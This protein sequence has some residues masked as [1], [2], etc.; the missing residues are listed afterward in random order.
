MSIKAK[1]ALDTSIVDQIYN[2]NVRYITGDI[3]QALLLDMSDSL[4]NKITDKNVVGGFMSP[5][6]TIDENRLVVKGVSGYKNSYLRQYGN[7]LAI[8]SGKFISSSTGVAKINLEDTYLDINLASDYSKSWIYADSAAK[9]TQF[10][11]DVY[12][13]SVMGEFDDAFTTNSNVI[14]MA[15]V[16]SDRLNSAGVFTAGVWINNLGG[17]VKQGVKAS[18]IIAGG[19]GELGIVAKTDNVLYTWTLGF[20]TDGVNETL[21]R[22]SIPTANNL[23]YIPDNSGTLALVT[24]ISDAL[25]DYLPKAGGVMTGSIN[26]ANYGLNVSGTGSSYIQY[27]TGSSSMLIHNMT[28]GSYLQLY[29]S[30]LMSLQSGDGEGLKYTADYTASF[31]TRSLVDKGYV[32]NV[33]VAKAGGTMSGALLADGGIDITGTGGSDVMN[34]GTTNADVI[35]IGRVGATVNI[36]GAVVNEYATNAYVTDKL[37]TLNSGGGAATAIGVGFEIEEAASIVGYIKSNG[38]RDGYLFLSPDIAYYLNL[39]L[40]NLNSNRTLTV[41]DINGIIATLNGGQTFTSAVWNGTAI[42]DAYISS[43]VTWNAKQNALVSGTNIKS[44]NGSSLLGAGNLAVGDALV[45]NSLAQFAPTTSAELEALIS[46]ETGSGLLVF[47]DSPVFT[48]QVQ[49]TGDI[50]LNTA[51][52]G[53]YVKEGVNATSGLATLVGGV[54]TVNTTKV[55]ANSRIQLTGQG[56]SIVNLGSY[57]VTARVA[58]TSFDISSSNFSD[59]NTVAWVIV[60]PL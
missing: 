33:F 16:N 11:Y 57:S 23:I 19:V 47:N 20:G 15:N 2:N 8:D 49:V 46:D 4:P 7:A 59:T 21:V 41:P 39:S 51:G 50:K 52:N 53:I 60:E 44:V 17:T 42:V 34:I 25:T 37:I 54:V 40:T 56:G 48:T 58:N 45:A 13:I 55:T 27:I 28:G 14:V 31:Q 12:G 18:V 43:A 36:L 5:E 35:N 9:I 29:D 10:G 38:T 30:G 6:S 22:Y 1:A 3:L 32:T 26:L 24:D